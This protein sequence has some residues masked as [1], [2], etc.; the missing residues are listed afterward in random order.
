MELASLPKEIPWLVR[1]EPASEAAIGTA[2][3]M[4]STSQLSDSNLATNGIALFIMVQRMIHEGS[5][6][7]GRR[8]NRDVEGTA[9]SWSGT[10]E[11]VLGNEQALSNRRFEHAGVYREESRTFAQ[12]RRRDEDSNIKISD[13]D[14]ERTFEGLVW[15]RV[16]ASILDS[17]WFK[18]CGGG[19]HGA[20]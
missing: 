5:E 8:S 19:L 10:T 14:L 3:A 4:A 20:C 17:G 16:D 2:Y 13:Q 18:K 15:F 1:L 9:K 6:R 12:N 7:L 11:L